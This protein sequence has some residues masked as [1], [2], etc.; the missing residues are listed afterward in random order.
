LK[1]IGI[2]EFH[3]HIRYL[4][5]LSKIC[6]TKQT[7]VTIF[8]N[9]DLLSKLKTYLKNLSD[10]EIVVKEEKESIK[11][12]LKRVEKICNEKI[13]LLFINTFQLTLFYLPRYI[14]FNPKCKT[15]F[16]I[17][18]VNA[19]LK[20]KPVFDFKQILKSI[21][22]N[23]SS[24]IGPK[25]LLPRYSA[26]NVV[27][28][29]L[30]DY[31]S[32]ETDYKKPVFTIPFGCFDHE[33]FE[34]DNTKEGKIKFVITG[35]IEEHR[36]DYDMILDAF[37]NIFPKYNNQIELI[38]LGYPVGPYGAN[39]IKRCKN[40][41][42]K[43]YNITYFDSFVPE[44]EYNELM[45]KVDFIILPIKIKSKSFGIIPEYYGI[46]KGN[47]GI[48]E[49]IQY[50]KPMIIPADFNM[51]DELKSSTFFFKDSK[52]LEETIEKLI[53]NKEKIKELKQT[54]YNNSKHFSVNILQSYFEKEILNKLDEL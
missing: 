11:S 22:T 28:P 27:Y 54:A 46:T 10:Y 1:N 31:I 4:Y 47:A 16:T 38:L 45:K 36:R 21:D 40:L 41:K 19:W 51:V 33:T 8:T 37:E 35:Q 42:D 34:D 26:A 15:V 13:D 3:C 25:L 43:N 23:L 44:K 50:A 18:V 12:F 52:N 5:I 2:L 6:K 14:S 48:F 32:K 20:P 29:T 24:F 39:I 7:N 9:K 49:G 30:K 53:E 17:H